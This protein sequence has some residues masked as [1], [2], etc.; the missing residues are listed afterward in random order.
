[1]DKDDWRVSVTFRDGSHTERLRQALHEHE[2]EAD[3]RDRLGGRVTVGEGDGVVFLYTSTRDAAREAERVV[4]DI[5]LAR[6]L[7]AYFA[8]HRWHPVE[9][10]WEDERVPL[11]APD[12]ERQ[13]E[14]ERL[15]EDEIVESE[16]LDGGLWEVRVE[17][18]SHHDA[19]TLAE[20]LQA[21]SDTLLPGW[22]VSVVRRWKYLLIGADNEDQANQIAQQLKRELPPGATIQVEPSGALAWQTMGRN[23]FAVFGG[24]G[25]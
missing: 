23:P 5:L 15:E 10:R 2:V 22:T 4:G 20:R 8:I 16:K 9:E 12:A 7:D 21:E 25:T 19:A 24:L 17:L 3:A 1:M 14:H 18:D 11:P 13:V 6:D